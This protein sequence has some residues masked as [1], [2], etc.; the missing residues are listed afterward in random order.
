MMGGINEPRLRLPDVEGVLCPQARAESKM[1]DTAKLP[2]CSSASSA[3]HAQI[4][5]LVEERAACR[6]RKD[7]TRADE[8]MLQ[9]KRQFNVQITVFGVESI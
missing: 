5:A 3:L 4:E 8:I 9:L 1:G 6:N 2:L 7:Y